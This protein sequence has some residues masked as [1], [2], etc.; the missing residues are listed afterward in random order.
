MAPKSDMARPD[1]YLRAF[2]LD[3]SDEFAS[4]VVSTP[5]NDS[6]FSRFQLSDVCNTPH[7]FFLRHNRAARKSKSK[8]QSALVR[9]KSGGC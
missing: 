9:R 1:D 5:A 4:F 3:G 2:L 7:Q 8:M 6:V